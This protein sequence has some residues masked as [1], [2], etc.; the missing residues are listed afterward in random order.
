MK[1]MSPW[2]LCYTA[3]N[4]FHAPHTLREV[5]PQEG[6]QRCNGGAQEEPGIQEVV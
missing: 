3:H 4:I 6:A 2:A 1:T 5:Y